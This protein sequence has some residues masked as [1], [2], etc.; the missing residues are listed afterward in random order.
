MKSRK[1]ELA[2]MDLVLEEITRDTK[3]KMKELSY[4]YEK[5]SQI[6]K[7][8]PACEWKLQEEEILTI[9]GRTSLEACEGCSRYY[10]CYQSEKEW[11]LEEVRHLLAKLEKQGTWVSI[12]LSEE[13]RRRCERPI[14]FQRALLQSYEIMGMNKIWCNK[15]LYQRKA[16]A[17]QME[18]MSRI[19]F[20]CSQRLGYEKGR[21][22]AKIRKFRHLLKKE[23][24][25][26]GPI[27][28][29]ENGAKRQ[30]IFLLACAKANPYP[31]ERVGKILGRLLRK[32]IVPAKDCRTA[33]YRDHTLLHFEEDRNYYVLCGYAG[34]EK[35]GH[36]MSGDVFSVLNLV[37]DR[38]VCILADGMGTGEKAREES[39][40]AVE[41]MEQFLEAGFREEETVRL[42][43]SMLTFG[44][45]RSMY[46]SFDFLSIHLYTGLMKMIKS[47]SAATFFVRNNQVEIV[48]SK[49]PPTGFLWEVEFDVLYKKLYDGD[50]VILLSDG[51]LDHLDTEMPEQCFGEKLLELLRENPQQTAREILS[52]VSAQQETK[53]L[54]DMS[55]LVVFI[56]KKSHPF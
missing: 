53:P 23:K 36:G 25:L 41:L 24:V 49:T 34:S 10:Q 40:H 35:E 50:K 18:E 11:L 2:Q 31:A 27:R 52:W 19:L 51:V 16:M 20:G 9:L 15:L 17:A 38:Q 43:N 54:D 4:S 46:S 6:L 26:L 28:F 33:V 12:S 30:E 55:V 44:L 22:P 5:L 42:T 47:G 45:E 1:K 56:W 32:N 48:S 13:G 37:P 29:Y 39:R 21:E 7:K 14:E 8:M 3:N